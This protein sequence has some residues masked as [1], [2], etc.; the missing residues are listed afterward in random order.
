MMPSRDLFARPNGQPANQW[1][2]TP[3]HRATVLL[4]LGE[5]L[6]G[7]SGLQAVRDAIAGFDAALEVRTRTAASA[8]WAVTGVH[9]ANAVWRLGMYLGGYE[10][11]V[12]LRAA[13]AVYEAALEILTREAMRDYWDT[14]QKNRARAQAVLRKRL[15]D[16]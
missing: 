12:A 15:E 6:C 5:R 10:E 14:A 1:A 8:D 3:H 7:E 11:L 4:T 9:R 13:I 16:E 2:M